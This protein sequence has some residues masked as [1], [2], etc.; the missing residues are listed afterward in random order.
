[1]YAALNAFRCK[2]GRLC[3][4]KQ[5]FRGGLVND[6]RHSRSISRCIVQLK[7]IGVVKPPALA[8]SML[9][10]EVRVEGLAIHKQK[11]LQIERSIAPAVTLVKP[12]RRSCGYFHTRG[13][14]GSGVTTVIMAAI[15]I[16][17]D[18]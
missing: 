3:A 12:T 7:S 13:P 6:S 15:C 4:G 9:E 8:L 18:H 16:A 5:S 1:M 11:G 14:T 10:V 17:R 2:Y